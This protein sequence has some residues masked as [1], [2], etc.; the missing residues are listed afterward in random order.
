MR[1]LTLH[2]GDENLLHDATGYRHG[3]LD[4]ADHHADGHAGQLVAEVGVPADQLDQLGSYR[5][6]NGC[7]QPTGFWWRRLHRSRLLILQAEGAESIQACWGR[8]G[9]FLTLRGLLPVHGV[10]SLDAPFRWWSRGSPLALGRFAGPVLRGGPVTGVGHG[11]GIQIA[12]DGGVHAAAGHGGRRVG[13]AGGSRGQSG[14]RGRGSG[15]QGIQGRG[16][17]GRGTRS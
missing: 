6:G 1:Y 17:H 10:G 11:A 16:A 13:R 9:S 8:R 2:H 15:V 14:L 12:C 7:H 5:L 3:A 4:V